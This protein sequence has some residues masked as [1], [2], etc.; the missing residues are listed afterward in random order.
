MSVARKL[1]ESPDLVAGVFLIWRFGC[2]T[3][4]LGVKKRKAVVAH[5]HNGMQNVRFGPETLWPLSSISDIQ[6]A[7]QASFE[8]SSARV[9]IWP[10]AI[11]LKLC[12]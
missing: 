6:P 3:D 9:I 8:A 2:A 5:S 12:S 1:E 10:H 11:A 7:H 4:C